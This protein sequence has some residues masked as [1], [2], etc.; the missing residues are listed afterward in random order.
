MPKKKMMKKPIIL[1]HKMLAG[2]KKGQTKMSKSDAGSAIFMED[3]AEDVVKKIKSAFCPEGVIV[4]NPCLEYFELIVFPSVKTVIVE[5]TEANGGHLTFNSFEELQK[6]FQLKSLHPVD[7]KNSLANY[8]NQ[9][10]EPVRKHFRE[11]PIAKNLFETIKS[12]QVTK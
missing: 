9:L 3:S 12:Y 1:S 4:D 6:S 10:I 7:L 5:R 8:L 11:D 2:L